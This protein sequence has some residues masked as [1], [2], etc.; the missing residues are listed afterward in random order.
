MS[1]EFATLIQDKQ[2]TMKVEEKVAARTTVPDESMI[3]KELLDKPSAGTKENA[4]VIVVNPASKP[5]ANL[6]NVC[7]SQGGCK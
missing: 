5:G 6:H 4:G 1:G 7:C 2:L 3:N